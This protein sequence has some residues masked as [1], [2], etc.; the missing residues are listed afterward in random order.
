M[1][2]IQ[3][4]SRD[5]IQLIAAYLDPIDIITLARACPRLAQKIDLH[6]REHFGSE[7]YAKFVDMMVRT[8]TCVSGSFV[9][10]MFLLPENEVWGGSDIDFFATSIHRIPGDQVFHEAE[11]F[12]HYVQGWDMGKQGRYT[13]APNKI[14]MVREFNIATPRMQNGTL[15]P[16][17][18]ISDNFKW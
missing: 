4:L 17:S 15:R 11:K 6:F 18:F 3:N 7:Y 16:E 12:F 10:Q 2:S 13:H 14:D 8:E 5:Q 1:T 9:L